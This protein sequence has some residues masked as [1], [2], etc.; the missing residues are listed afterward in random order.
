MS[1]SR[2]VAGLRAVEQLI[3]NEQAKISRLY[4]EY[5][6]ANPRVEAIIARANAR[7]IEIHSANRARLQQISG[8]VRLQ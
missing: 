2:Y 7:G 3:G 6:S 4:A 1:R 5:Q 8:E